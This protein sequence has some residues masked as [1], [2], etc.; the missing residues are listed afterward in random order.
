MNATLPAGRGPV[1]RG[2]NVIGLTGN[3]GAGKSTVAA[4]LQN[5]GAHV[6][7]ADALGYQMLHS[8]SPVFSQLIDTFGESILNETGEISRIKLGQVVFS[9]PAKLQQL[10]NLV[11]PP[12]LEEIHRQIHA[13]RQSADTGLWVLDAAL[14]FEWG[15]EDWFDWIVVVSAP[16]EIRRQRFETLR[17]GAG[18]RFD[19]RE[20]AQLPQEFKEK[21]ADVVVHN[22][23]DQKDLQRY[24]EE[25]FSE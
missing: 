18:N 19:E 25:I 2:K 20:A 11:H 6:T 24:I 5:R 14:L 22:L 7:V 8:D 9:D 13:F 1:I 10:N 16:L 17:P 15:I 12:M 21:H 4:I 3:P 23:G